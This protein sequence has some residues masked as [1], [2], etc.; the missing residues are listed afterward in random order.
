[1]R[2]PTKALA[3]FFVF[4]GAMHFVRPRS[5]EAIVPPYVP[6]QREAV[7]ISAI[8]EIAGG[9]AVLHPATQG[10]FM[11]WTWRATAA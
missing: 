8:A 2:G 3:T 1:V 5:Y 7:Q 11:L 6:R 4:A 9:L 10:L